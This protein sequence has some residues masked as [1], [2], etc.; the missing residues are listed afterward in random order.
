MHCKSKY[1]D[2]F[3]GRLCN[4]Y[5]TIVFDIYIYIIIHNISSYTLLTYVVHLEFVCT[6]LTPLDQGRV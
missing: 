3:V 1:I 2:W 5:F 4:D 6:Y